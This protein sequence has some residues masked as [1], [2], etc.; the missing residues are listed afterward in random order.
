MR[1]SNGQDDP[2]C[3]PGASTHIGA[4]GAFH[5]IAKLPSMIEDILPDFFCM[6]VLAAFEKYEEQDR[7]K[8]LHA[9]CDLSE[10]TAA[11][12]ICKK[13]DYPEDL[14]ALRQHFIDS[15]GDPASLLEELMAT[16]QKENI[17]FYLNDMDE[18][19][20]EQHL[21]DIARGKVRSA[22]EAQ[23]IKLTDKPPT[24]KNIKALCQG[25]ALLYVLCRYFV[26]HLP[27]YTASLHA[28]KGLVAFLNMQKL[29]V[30]PEN[31]MQRLLSDQ[32]FPSLV[33]IEDYPPNVTDL[34]SV[35]KKEKLVT[36]TTSTPGI[37][38]SFKRK[39]KEINN[40]IKRQKQNEGFLKILQNSAS[41]LKE[42]Q[43][44]FDC[45]QP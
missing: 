6:K 32:I 25:N 38:N 31:E 26:E 20:V 36:E 29:C 4:M 35:L 22:L 2:A 11:D 37:F 16:Y 17:G 15:L 28:V 18:K 33:G 12:V 24:P 8:M 1:N 19:L 3:F 14:L 13:N 41:T 45:C 42:K 30:L 34:L 44:L 9:L 39:R 5:P 7:E 40:S 27:A 21:M 10:E 23:F 43:D